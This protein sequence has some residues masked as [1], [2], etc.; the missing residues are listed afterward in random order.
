MEP[1]KEPQALESPDVFSSEICLGASN[2]S[3]P[4]SKSHRL[5]DTSPHTASLLLFLPSLHNPFFT[6]QQ[7]GCE[8]FLRST[9]NHVT[10]QR[11]LIPSVNE[12]HALTSANAVRYNLLPSSAVDDPLPLRCPSK[13]P[14][15]LLLI[16]FPPAQIC[17]RF[18]A[19]T[20][21]LPQRAFLTTTQSCSSIF[22]IDLCSHAISSSSLFS[23]LSCSPTYH[24][25]M[26]FRV[27]TTPWTYLLDF[28]VLSQN[29]TSRKAAHH[30]S[31]ACY[32]PRG[33]HRAQP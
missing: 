32:N 23:L 17:L 21:H 31:M 3:P 30:L 33:Q 18:L 10:L 16:P 28:Q 9:S 29:I 19:W 15:L 1:W 25:F 5:E 12:L 14:S 8:T 13:Q 4:D 7:R 6:Q 27:S 11:P 2:G 20:I 26:V 24:C 22:P